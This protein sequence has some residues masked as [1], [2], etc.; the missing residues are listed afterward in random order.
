MCCYYT[1]C[2]AF[3]S[4]HSATTFKTVCSLFAVDSQC[5]MNHWCVRHSSCGPSRCAVTSICGSRLSHTVRSS[6]SVGFSRHMSTSSRSMSPLIRSPL[7]TRPIL[8][9][10][11]KP[12]PPV[13]PLLQLLSSLRHREHEHDQCT[14]NIHTQ[15]WSPN[16]FIK[17]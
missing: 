15:F 2:C 6:V 13:G 4:S 8:I 17:H 9:T 16:H 1:E 11:H 14:C 7:A 10:P 3:K 12:P 5:C